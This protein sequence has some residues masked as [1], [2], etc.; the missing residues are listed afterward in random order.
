MTETLI[1]NSL[2]IWQKVILI[3]LGIIV[4]PITLTGI[5]FYFMAHNWRIFSEPEEWHNK[6]Q[7][8]DVE[9]VKKEIE[10]NRDETVKILI[11]RKDR[12]EKIGR[13]NKDADKILNDIHSA[14]TIVEL[15]DIRR[16][17]RSLK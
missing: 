13:T 15:E 2:K 4:L 14:A 3:I 16:R 10:G 1:W 7:N 9:K 17:I 11:R 8:E 5:V 6:K 12:L